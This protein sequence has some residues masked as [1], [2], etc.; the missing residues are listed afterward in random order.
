VLVYIGPLYIINPFTNPEK[1]IDAATSL[2]PFEEEAT[3]THERELSRAIQVTPESVV[4]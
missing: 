1:A 2:V 4:V 3:D